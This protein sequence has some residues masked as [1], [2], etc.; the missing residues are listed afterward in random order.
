[1]REL[2]QS[3]NAPLV[4]RGSATLPAAAMRRVQSAGDGFQ[5]RHVV[6][7]LVPEQLDPGVVGPVTAG[8]GLARAV[9]VDLD[10]VPLEPGHDGGQLGPVRAG[11]RG[12]VLDQLVRL[13]VH[14]IPVPADSPS[15]ENCT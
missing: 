9:P 10:P 4:R 14:H 11:H 5:C 8:R 12:P 13:Q 6:Q 2:S 7:A 15:A 1:M 3:Q